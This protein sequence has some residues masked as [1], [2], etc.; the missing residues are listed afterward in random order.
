[1]SITHERNA[2]DAAGLD[3]LMGWFRLQ[4]GIVV[5][6]CEGLSDA[7]AHRSVLPTSPLMTVAGVVSLEAGQAGVLDP[8]P[9]APPGGGAPFSNF[10]Y[11]LQ[12]LTF[13][14]VALVALVIF[15]RLE[16]LQRRGKRERTGTLRDQLSGR[17][18]YGADEHTPTG[19]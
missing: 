14:V 9:V 19:S 4:R 13:G 11:A 16:M 7:Q 6:K 8:I 17:D 15:I 1:M 5:T 3:Q 10:S 18:G 12:W 2:R